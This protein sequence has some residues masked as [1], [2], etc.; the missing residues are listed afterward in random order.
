MP[1]IK[2]IE[3]SAAER[4]ALEQGYHSGTSPAFRRRCQI[5]LLKSPGRTSL[6]VAHIVGGCEMAV[7][8]WIHRYQAH[9]IQGLHTRPGRGRK[10]I[11]QNS[12]LESVQAAVAGHRQRLSVAK[13]QLEQSLNKSFSQMTLRRFVKKTVASINDCANVPGASRCRK[14]TRS[15]SSA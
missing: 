12:D 13:A 14:F 4:T 10:A 15:K 7:N 9:G 11:L 5:L 6:E 3:L 1:K 8:N 2:V